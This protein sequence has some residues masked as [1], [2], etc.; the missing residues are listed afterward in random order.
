MG[1]TGGFTTPTSGRQEQQRSTNDDQNIVSGAARPVRS[2]R[3]S[4]HHA[5]AV[6]PATAGVG[7]TLNL[8]PV[9]ADDEFRPVPARRQAQSRASPIVELPLNTISTCHYIFDCQPCP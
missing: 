6:T 1:R 8:S 3:N 4:L 2:T 9:I 5:A 7:T